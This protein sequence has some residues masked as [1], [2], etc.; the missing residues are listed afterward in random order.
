MIIDICMVF[1]LKLNA[2]RVMVFES[3]VTIVKIPVSYEINS[4]VVQMIENNIISSSRLVDKIIPIISPKFILNNVTHQLL[5]VPNLFRSHYGEYSDGGPCIIGRSCGLNIAGQQYNCFSTDQYCYYPRWTIQ[6][7]IEIFIG[8]PDSSSCCY[9][10]RCA[11]NDCL[12]ISQLYYYN[13]L[14]DSNSLYYYINGDVITITPEIQL[15]TTQI[16][17]IFDIN[18]PVIRNQTIYN[19]SLIYEDIQIYSA[20]PKSYDLFS[21]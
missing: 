15:I 17:E 1:A 12:S 20:K 5:K 6:G 10:F 11:G 21:C 9:I 3:T 4:R 19:T 16:S 14:L 2:N 13:K 8:T 7:E 18:V